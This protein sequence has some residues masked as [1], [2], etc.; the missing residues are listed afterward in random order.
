MKE[1]LICFEIP[2]REGLTTGHAIETVTALT[3]SEVQRI[4]QQLYDRHAT[5]MKLRGLIPAGQLVIRSLTRLDEEL[6]IE[7]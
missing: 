6:K 4:A 1:V 7:H 3:K 5:A 2:C